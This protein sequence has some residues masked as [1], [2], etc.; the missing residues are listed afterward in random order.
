MCANKFSLE[1]KN[2]L[3]ICPENN[4]GPEVVEGL[5]KAGCKVFLAGPN[6][7]AMEAIGADGIYVYDHVLE[8]QQIL[9]LA[10]VCVVEAVGGHIHIHTLGELTV[11]GI[12]AQIPRIHGSRI[13]AE[14]LLLASGV[15]IGEVEVVLILVGTVEQE[16]EGLYLG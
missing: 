2:A 5:K 9:A 3:V 11:K 1:G 8:P 14:P 10:V 7:E 13:P 12:I 6:K 15:T 4:W 16:N